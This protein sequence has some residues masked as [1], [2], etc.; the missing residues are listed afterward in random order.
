MRT[1][2]GIQ[3]GASRLHPPTLGSKNPGCLSLI[4]VKQFTVPL[5]HCQ[6]KGMEIRE[7]ISPF[8]AIPHTLGVQPLAM[9]LPPC[10]LGFSSGGFVGRQYYSVPLQLPFLLHF[11]NSVYV[12][13]MV[14]LGGMVPS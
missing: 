6:P 5:P 2:C 1:H 3:P 12:F 13:S 7:L 11:P 8:P 10:P 4:H 14:R 9:Q